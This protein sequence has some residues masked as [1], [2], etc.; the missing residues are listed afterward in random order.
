MRVGGDDR[1]L[2][3]R[4]CRRVQACRAHLR[5]CT[6]P[7]AHQHLVLIQHHG[8]VRRASQLTDIWLA[9]SVLLDGHSH[10][11][12]GIIIK[13]RRHIL[14][15]KLVGGVTDEQA[16]L[17]HSTVTDDHASSGE[18]SVSSAELNGHRRTRP[19][20]ERRNDVT[21]L[22]VATTIVNVTGQRDALTE[23]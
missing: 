12:D 18:P 17:A 21:H 7:D 1:S 10:H 13:H 11:G 22:I 6:R 9:T 19:S 16:G 4:P 2:L 3:D 20:S 23:R 14:R 8:P 15:G 5:S